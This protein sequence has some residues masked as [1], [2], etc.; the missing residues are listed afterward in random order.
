MSRTDVVTAQHAELGDLFAAYDP[1]SH[2]LSPG[3]RTSRFA[4][5]L[6]PFRS[7][8]EAEAALLQEGAVM[9]GKHVR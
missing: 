6:A 4:A 3:V 2:H 8:D 5:F 1:T 7:R 9:V